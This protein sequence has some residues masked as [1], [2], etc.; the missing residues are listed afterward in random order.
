MKLAEEDEAARAKKF[1][2]EK[3]AEEDE[4]ARAK[5]LDEE[6][7]EAKRKSRAKIKKPSNAEFMEKLEK[8]TRYQPRFVPPKELHPKLVERIANLL[9]LKDNASLVSLMLAMEEIPRETIEVMYNQQFSTFAKVFNEELNKSVN[10]PDKV[11]K[12]RKVL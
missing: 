10:I 6:K 2:D 5:Q 7:P 3:L 11:S 4:A 1:A 8:K 12:V 9:S